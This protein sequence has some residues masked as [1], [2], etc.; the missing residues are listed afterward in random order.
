MLVPGVNVGNGSNMNAFNLSVSG[1]REYANSI[2]LD[3]IESTTNRTQDVTVT[4]NVDSVEEFKVVTS[5]FNA[6]FGNAAGGV[7]AVQT[8]AGSN[9]FH[10]DA[11]EFFRPNFLTARQTI[12]GVDAPQP[13]PTLK[14]HNF[15]GTFGGPIK[16]DRSF[17]FV[18]YEGMRNKDAY[19]YV[20]ST[21]PFGLFD[22]KPNGDVDF[23][24]L[25]DPSAGTVDP[26]YDP[27]S[28]LDSWVYSAT[29]F[30]GN[31]I[32][33]SRVSQAGMNTLLNFFPKP[34]LTGTHNGWFRNF[35]AHAPVNHNSNQVDSR[36]D[37][38]ITSK[39]RL[40]AVY[41]WQGYN[42]LANDAWY[43]QNVVKG[44]GDADQGTKENAGA[45]SLSLTYDHIF[46]PKA[47][48]EVRF[49]YLRYS[50]DQYSLLSGTDYSSKYGFGNVAI[51][52]YPATIG[53]PDIYMADGYLAGGSSW[54]PFHILDENYQLG[55]SFTW[56]GVPRHE[57]K[58]GADTRAC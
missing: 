35:Q 7:I 19:N 42:Y 33:A 50:Q 1:Q 25:A 26:I 46:S 3:G 34:N 36:F 55:D 40:Y 12:P 5:S 24:R 47:L 2:Q 56:S 41:H 9:A 57:F 39:D 37:Q 43:G 23:S 48:N 13:A 15:G 38:V 53:F 20:T 51:Q 22:I 52:D 28:E 4:P 8:K 21:L 49:G 6:E 29:Q 31:V 11:F 44:S 14:Q 32:P 45:Q 16:K 10:G 30:P 58:F 18:A 54:K 17:F 27:N